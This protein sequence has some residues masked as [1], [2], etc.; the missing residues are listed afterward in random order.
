MLMVL[1]KPDMWTIELQHVDKTINMSP[2]GLN[3]DSLAWSVNG[4]NTKYSTEL[5]ML[6]YE[7]PIGR[8]SIVN[9]SDPVVRALYAGL[10]LYTLA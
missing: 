10:V 4:G 1:I 8:K 3:D 7:D 2:I 5:D 6:L 9:Y